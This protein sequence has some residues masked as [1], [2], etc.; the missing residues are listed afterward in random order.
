MACSYPSV[1]WGF[2]IEIKT[3]VPAHT[4][5]VH[6]GVLERRFGRPGKRALFGSEAADLGED[7]VN[8]KHR[9]DRPISILL[10]H[11][12]AENSGGGTAFSLLPAVGIVKI[13]P[14]IILWIQ[15]Y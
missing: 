6:T 11:G 12:Q 5:V 2:L 9:V 13:A 4:A 10:F 3:T 8:S 15:G 14:L 7:L 1:S